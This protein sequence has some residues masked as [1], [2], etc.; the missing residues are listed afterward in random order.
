MP[1]CA[2]CDRSWSIHE[3]DWRAHAISGRVLIELRNVFPGEASP[4]DLLLKCLQEQ[5]GEPWRYAW[6]AYLNE[7]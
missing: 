4:S 2:G 7:D 5:S 3:L 6:A 1:C